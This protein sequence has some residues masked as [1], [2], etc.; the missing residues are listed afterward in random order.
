[1]L[2]NKLNV[3]V[4]PQQYPTGAGDIGGIF[5]R[6]YVRSI[7]GH[8]NV[9]VLVPRENAKP[10]LH[11]KDES[12]A[13]EKTWTFSSRMARLPLIKKYGLNYSLG[14]IRFPEPV[15]LIHAHGPVFFGNGAL[16]LGRRM[17]VPVVVTVHTSSFTR[18]MQRKFVRRI[19]SDTLTNVDCVLAVSHDQ[20]SIMKD[21]GIRPKRWE[22]LY[23]PVDTET[24]AMSEGSRENRIVWS[25][26]FEKFK[27]G[28]RTI[29]AFEK[30]MKRHPG[31]TLELIGDGPERG[32]IEEYLIG[33][34]SL[35]KHVILHGML[36]KEKMAKV[37]SKAQ[38]G[39][40]P[41]EHETFGLVLVEAMA[42]GLPVI[43]PDRSAPLEY[44]D[45]SNGY[46]VDPTNIDA[47]S[48]SMATM[49]SN[50][51]NFDRSGIRKTVVNRFGMKSFGQKLVQLYRELCHSSQGK[52]RV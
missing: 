34:D 25:G 20:M 42:A 4:I 6:D 26:R 11:A 13:G 52:S 32:E 3:L 39:V 48:E 41:T 7:A 47:I 24:F 10:G 21:E 35:R 30:L 44:L 50:I 31:W 49:I 18:L 2:V 5:V 28:L 40:F 43:G 27:G 51:D 1:M 9:N 8:C 23:N 45:G 14:K 33:N 17:N 22:V 37:L 19:I 38:F 16:N 29:K 15:D 36:T 12:W 46:K